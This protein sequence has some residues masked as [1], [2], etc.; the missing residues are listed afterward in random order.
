[1][2]TFFNLATFFEVSKKYKNDIALRYD[3]QNITYDELNKLSNRIATI[4]FQ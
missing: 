3:N 4:L 1:M 2:N